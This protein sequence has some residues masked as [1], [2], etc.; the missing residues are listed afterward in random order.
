MRTRYPLIAGVV[1]AA[2]ALAGW[3]AAPA[4]AGNGHSPTLHLTTRTDQFAFV[5]QGPPGPSVGD[6]LVFSD[7]VFRDGVRVGTSTSTCVMTKVTATTATCSQVIAFALPEGQLVLQGI[8]EG[9]NRPPQP[10]EQFR[11]ALA[12]TG[13]TG[14]YRTARGDADG[15]DLAGGEEQYTIR[16]IR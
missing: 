8:T 16:I 15:V 11:F 2:A 10:G 7:T 14:A 3:S 13:G 6:Q 12:V 4:A 9:P 5:D 1:L